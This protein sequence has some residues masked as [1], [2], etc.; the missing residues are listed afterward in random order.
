ML[1]E[2]AE[3][4]ATKPEE[5]PP[6]TSE[7]EVPAIQENEPAETPAAEPAAE[8][9]EE[10]AEET[11]EYSRFKEIYGEL[12]RTQRENEQ[13]KSRLPEDQPRTPQQV[14][15][16]AK[17]EI[18]DYGSYEEFSEALT[19]WKLDEREAARAQERAK[20]DQEQQ[21][22]KWDNRVSE[23][24]AKDPDFLEKGYIP[25]GLVPMLS[26]TEKLSD[27]AYYFGENPQEVHRIMKLP[28]IQAAVE[29]GR[30]EAGFKH[31]PPQ[32]KT[33]NAPNPTSPVIGNETPTKDPNDMSYEEYKAWRTGGGK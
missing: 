31:S 12:K 7:P 15:G 18:D 20:Q 4:G 1:E 21:Q 32:R 13:L 6:S 24:V 29:I 25:A 27:F 19:D 17:P 26:E 11:V 10:P 33:T 14:G 23:A 22:Q 5:T 3:P 30:L 28:Q 2:Q 8:P 9:A 16:K